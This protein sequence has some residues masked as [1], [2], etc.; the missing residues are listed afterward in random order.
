MNVWQSKGGEKNQMFV[1]KVMLGLLLTGGK[2]AVRHIGDGRCLGC[3]CPK[4]TLKHIFWECPVIKNLLW[5]VCLWF[6]NKFQVPFF[7][8]DLILD[9]PGHSG[10]RKFWIVLLRFATWCYEKYGFIKMSVS[11]RGSRPPSK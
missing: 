2:I 3:Q 8:R 9:P 11:F 6:H 5:Q 4:E 1:I 7:K 10:K